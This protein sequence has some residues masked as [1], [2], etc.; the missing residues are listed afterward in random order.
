M[1]APQ[2]AAGGKASALARG[3]PGRCVVVRKVIKI[4]CIY[5]IC[6]TAIQ[7]VTD[8]QEIAC[9]TTPS[10]AREM[11]RISLGPACHNKLRRAEEDLAKECI[12]W[13]FE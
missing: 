3:E 9:A 5:G 1:I 6:L 2:G 7:C 13:V 8:L 11:G 10:S 12:P 4:L